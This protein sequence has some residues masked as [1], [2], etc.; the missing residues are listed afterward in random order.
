MKFEVLKRNHLKRN[1]LIGVVAIFIISA[2][3][4]NLSSAKYRVR[5]SVPIIHS[6]INYIPY[7]FKIMAMYQEN[8]TGEYT[9][10]ESMPSNGYIIN[11]EMSYCT[12][13]NVNKDESARVYTD[14]KGQHVFSGL[15]KSSK[16]YL[17]F[18]KDQKNLNDEILAKIT[19]Q[20]IRTDFSTIVNATTTGV[21][22]YADTD[23]GRTYYFAGA[24]TDN[25][26]YFAGFY[27][28][29][30]RINEDGSIRLI[31]SGDS[32]SGPVET[33]EATQIGKSAFN[34]EYLR[35]NMYVGYMYQD[36]KVHGLQNDST[37]KTVLD[38]WYQNNLLIYSQ[39]IST[40]AGFCGDREPSISLTT[41][42]G[43]GGTGSTTTYYGASIRLNTNKA[44]SFKC[45]NE[46]DLY[47]VV[48]SNQGNKAL[49]YPIGLI[50]ADEVSFAGGVFYSSNSEYYLYTNQYYWT[51]TPYNLYD[52][53]RA[54]A[55]YVFPEGGPYF[56]NVD[57]A[58]GVRPVI[59]LSE[60]VTI[61]GSGTSTDP[62]TV[63]GA[64]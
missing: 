8:D 30:I 54:T 7:D 4:F 18:D 52:G 17:Y 38:K 28:R 48:S 22:Y 9:E 41:S 20:S 43:K 34:S 37:I 27:W 19:T 61:T 44:P 12:L 62:Y 56:N 14:D 36:G 16:C 46:S 33:G 5:N 32:S 55:F 29:I 60:N 2:I 40:K 25:W 21:I 50:T 57:S 51:M 31:Y 64:S 3:I 24:P 1:I 35:N 13:D 49:T 39:Y 26:V 47:T 10:I 6:E 11:E 58:Y 45:K 23:T 63:V 15:K 53:I 59:N 42:N